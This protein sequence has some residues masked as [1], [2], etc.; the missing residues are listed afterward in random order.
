MEKPP[1]LPLP[2]GALKTKSASIMG[3]TFVVGLL[4]LILQ[5]PVLMVGHVLSGRSAYR[6]QAMAEIGQSW[7]GA[8]TVVGPVLVVPYRVETTVSE[9]TQVGERWVRSQ[10]LKTVAGMAYFLPE[11]FSAD[12]SMECSSRARDLPRARV[13]RALAVPWIFPA[14]SGGAEPSAD[15]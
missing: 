7:G 2:I 9:Q 14:G 4:V 6:D 8:Q 11:E 13:C 10:A 1:S 5:V 15:A 3:K 12:G